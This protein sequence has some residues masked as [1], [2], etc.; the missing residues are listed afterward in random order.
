[1]I[2]NT[3]MNDIILIYGGRSGEHDVSLRSG[4]YIYHNIKKC[5]F[6]PHPVGISREG[7]WYSQSFSKEPNDILPLEEKEENRLSL[8]PGK[9]FLLPNG[10]QLSCDMVFPVIH[11]TFGEDGTLQGLLEM[12]GLPYVGA[13]LQSSA[14]GMDKVCAKEIWEKE[15]LPV[16]PYKQMLKEIWMNNN[17]NKIN[18]YLECR[19]E[20]SLPLFIKPS[21][22]GS[23]VGV[24]RV[25]EEK[26]FLTA[27]DEALKYDGEILIEKAVDAREIECSLIGKAEPRIFGPGE[28]APTH[29]FYD[30]D[31]KYIDPEG[32]V[33]LIPA[34]IE[35]DLA[36]RI[37]ETALKAYKALK[38]NGLSRVDL[39]LEKNSQT[40]YLNEVNT[41]P[42]FTSISMFPQLCASEGLDG[43]A[44]I[45][46]LIDQGWEDFQEKNK[47]NYYK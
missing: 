28:I 42:G 24:F 4:A 1:M 11:G 34:P 45:K 30:Y 7:I 47:L 38:L 15:G 18:F 43:P 36:N 6:I 3:Y 37:R 22:A 25:M 20:L 40:Y 13:N 23:S 2:D 32:A 19:K 29:D 8:M 21:R 16:V 9:G 26:S 41:M 17:F 5:G 10:R 35:E 31:A 14:I 46:E 39:F 12:M 27:M 44:L 33:L